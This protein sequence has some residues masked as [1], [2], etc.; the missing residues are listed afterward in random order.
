VHAVRGIRH[1]ITCPPL[2]SAPPKAPIPHQRLYNRTLPCIK[3]SSNSCTGGGREAEEKGEEAQL[4]AFYILTVL[5]LTISKNAQP[6]R[7]PEEEKEGKER[8][9]CLG[10][11]EG[12]VAREAT[13]ENKTVRKPEKMR[14]TREGERNFS[15]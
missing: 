7:D 4:A 14:Q 13:N 8:K 6:I 9:K 11:L 15:T 2:A 12:G 5:V 3:V 1:H 10:W